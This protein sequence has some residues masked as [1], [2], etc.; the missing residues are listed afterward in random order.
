MAMCL[1][2]AILNPLGIVTGTEA[3]A[4]PSNQTMRGRMT[5]YTGSHTRTERQ[6]SSKTGCHCL[7]GCIE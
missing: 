2:E 4:P 5:P 3:Q 6:R 7:P 1:A